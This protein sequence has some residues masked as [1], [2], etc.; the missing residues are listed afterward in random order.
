MPMPE[1]PDVPDVEIRA[2]VKAR[3]LRFQA[4]P[5]VSTHTEAEPGGEHASGSD[6]KNLPAQVTAGVT[7]HDIQLD[8]RLAARLTAPPPDSLTRLG[9][10]PRPPAQPT[11]DPRPESSSQPA[12]VSAPAPAP[13]HQPPAEL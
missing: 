5:E 9:L 12:P 4:R 8:F 2:S 1:R 13:D 6:R 3:E 7:Y 11:P 10:E